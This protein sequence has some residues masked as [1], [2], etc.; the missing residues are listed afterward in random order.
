M[1]S[2]QQNGQVIKKTAEYKGANKKGNNRKG[3]R[4]I[5]KLT[6][7]KKKGSNRVN[8]TSK[9]ICMHWDQFIPNVIFYTNI[10]VYGFKTINNGKKLSILKL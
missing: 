1:K 8:M 3:N 5:G 4:K 10:E 6:K 9:N 2:C 7:L